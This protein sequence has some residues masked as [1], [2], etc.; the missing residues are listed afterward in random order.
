MQSLPILIPGLL[1][2]LMLLTGNVPAYGQNQTYNYCIVN[3]NAIIQLGSARYGYSL[4]IMIYQNNTEKINLSEIQVTILLD[5]ETDVTDQFT[6]TKNIEYNGPTTKLNITIEP[7]TVL[8]SLE[9]NRYHDIIIV[10]NTTILAEIYVYSGESPCTTTSGENNTWTN[11]LQPSNQEYTREYTLSKEEKKTLP[12]PET[13]S[14]D[15]EIL[16]KVLTLPL[17]ILLVALTIASMVI[18]YARNPKTSN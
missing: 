2:T 14:S 8:G 9:P 10:A 12:P 13:Q 18:E 6:I 15:K 7:E 17:I 4:N 11:T 3:G 16:K 1:L 5:G